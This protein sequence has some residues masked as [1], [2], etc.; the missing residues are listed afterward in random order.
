MGVSNNLRAL[1]YRLG[2]I[3]NDDEAIEEILNLSD[4]TKTLLYRA[5]QRL[6]DDVRRNKNSRRFY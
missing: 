1:L 6:E 5:L 2:Y 4:K 3:S